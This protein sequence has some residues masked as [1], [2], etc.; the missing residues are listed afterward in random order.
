MLPVVTESGGGGPLIPTELEPPDPSVAR[1]L[2]KCTVSLP[3]SLTR[4]H[5]DQTLDA[6]ERAASSFSSWQLSPVLR[7][8]LVLPLNEQDEIEL[9]GVRLRYDSDLGLVDE[10]V[11]REERP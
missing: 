11:D 3:P 1:I 10:P 4:F 9:C 6:L 5:F 2:A 8:E 7:G